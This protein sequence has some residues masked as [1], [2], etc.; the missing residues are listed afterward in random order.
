MLPTMAALEDE[1]A[2]IDI[3][4]RAMLIQIARCVTS[5]MGLPMQKSICDSRP[6]RRPKNQEPRGDLNRPGDKLI[7]PESLSAVLWP[8]E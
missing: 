1:S 7:T 4:A 6:A 5:L 8:I 3:R 2:P